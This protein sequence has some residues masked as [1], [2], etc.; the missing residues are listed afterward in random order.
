MFRVSVNLPGGS[1]F[2]VKNWDG[3]T[4]C[5]YRLAYGTLEHWKGVVFHHKLSG[6]WLTYPSEKCEFVS[7]DYESQIYGKIKFMFQTTNQVS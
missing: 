7:W 2:F 1:I 3:S 5:V 6:W 4:R